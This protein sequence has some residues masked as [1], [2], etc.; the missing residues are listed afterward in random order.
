MMFLQITYPLMTRSKQRWPIEFTPRESWISLGPSRLTPIRNWYCWKKAAHSSSKNVAFVCSELLIIVWGGASPACKE[1]TCSKNSSS[2][3]SGSLPY[4]AKEAAPFDLAMYSMMNFSS[5]AQGI[6]L[7][8]RSSSFFQLYLW[9]Y[10]IECDR[11]H[12]ESTEQ[13]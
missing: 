11:D 7:L 1:T 13:S 5:T 2:T 4:Q 12:N 10:S 8:K 3:S 9:I 6:V